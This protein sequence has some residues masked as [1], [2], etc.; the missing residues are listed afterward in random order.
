MHDRDDELDVS[1]PLTAQA[2]WGDFDPTFLTDKARSTLVAI[3]ATG[4]GPV[5]YWTK[6]AL[7][8]KSVFLR[9]VGL[10]V[11]GV[12]IRDLTRTPGADLLW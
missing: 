8:E 1:H 7:T 9:L 11:D 5:L 10:I 6:D 4:T 12:R 2:T 3:L